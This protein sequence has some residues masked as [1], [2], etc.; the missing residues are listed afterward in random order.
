MLGGGRLEISLFSSSPIGV[1]GSVLSPPVSWQLYFSFSPALPW[2][3][4][5]LHNR[6]ATVGLPVCYPSK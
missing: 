2:K 1:F 4:W 3:G 6:Y 5:H